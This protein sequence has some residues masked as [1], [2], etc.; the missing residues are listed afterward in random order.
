MVSGG[1]ISALLQPNARQF[2]AG[3]SKVALR[4]IQQHPGQFTRIRRVY[5]RLVFI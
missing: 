4:D 3:T 1:Q 2:V 5:R